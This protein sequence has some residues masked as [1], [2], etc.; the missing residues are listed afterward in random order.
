[1]A[2][3]KR[4]IDS[5]PSQVIQP[6]IAYEEVTALP[7]ELRT[8]NFSHAPLPSPCPNLQPY[9]ALRRLKLQK[10]KSLPNLRW[11]APVSDTLSSL[12]LDVGF[13]YIRY[14]MMMSEHS[15]DPINSIRTFNVGLAWKVCRSLCVRNV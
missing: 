9:K 4:H 11:L 1:M 10:V 6:E 7:H 8:L 12:W 5:A 2:K 3:I 14:Q 13:T 15:L